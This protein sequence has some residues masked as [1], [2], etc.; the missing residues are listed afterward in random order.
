MTLR[1]ATSC[2][3]KEIS[4]SDPDL[5]TLIKKKQQIFV[6]DSKQPKEYII[7]SLLKFEISLRKCERLGVFDK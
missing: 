7:D 6:L 5:T 1:K 4:K 2:E 3:I